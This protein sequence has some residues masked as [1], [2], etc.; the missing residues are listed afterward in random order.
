MTLNNHSSETRTI[1]ITSYAEVVL[2]S[3]MSDLTHPA[4]SNLFVQT[5]LVPKQNAIL[6]SR[7]PRAS[8]DKPPWS[9]YLLLVHGEEAGTTTFETDRAKFIG[10][11]GNITSPAA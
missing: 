11:A 8:H 6:C 5:H 3:P 1:E 9:F 4:F 7:R 2:N 10:R